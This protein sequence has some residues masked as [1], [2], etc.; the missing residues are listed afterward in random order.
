[1]AVTRLPFDALAFLLQEKDAVNDD[2]AFS[3]TP[4]CFD[5]F[6]YGNYNSTD[7]AI[8]LFSSVNNSVATIDDAWVDSPTEGSLDPL[9]SALVQLIMKFIR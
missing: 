4:N 8:H 5:C 2:A 9:K 3:E 1:M 6:R 7:K